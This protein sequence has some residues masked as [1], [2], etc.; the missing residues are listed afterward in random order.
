MIDDKIMLAVP[1]KDSYVDNIELNLYCDLKKGDYA[2][3]GL[4]K[5]K[6]ICAVGKVIKIVV[7]KNVGGNY[8]TNIPVTDDEKTRFFEL[9][10]RLLQVDSQST[11][12]QTEEKIYFVD[13]FYPTNYKNIGTMGI[14]GSKKFLLEKLLPADTAE[15]A[16]QLKE[17]TWELI[18]GQDIVP[19]QKNISR[20]V[21]K[22]ILDF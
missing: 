18:K 11:F 10:K 20:P 7:F 1:V 22:R 3:L 14:M 17:Q 5:D 16:E 4:Y 6:A 9:K 13:K 2:Y 8:E 21:R 12:G 19:E 15:I